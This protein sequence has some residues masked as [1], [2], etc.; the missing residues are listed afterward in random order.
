M[1]RSL[2]SVL[3]HGFSGRM[4]PLVERNWNFLSSLQPRCT[5]FEQ[6]RP[7]E[8]SSARS[9]FWLSPFIG[10]VIPPCI[11]MRC[12]FW[13]RSHLLS[14]NSRTACK[15]GVSLL[16]IE[17]QFSHGCY[18]HCN[19]QHLCQCYIIRLSRADGRSPT[20]GQ[21]F[22]LSGSLAAPFTASFRDTALGL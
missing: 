18:P 17:L 21:V 11:G 8:W 5:S 15:V 10:T 4:Y 6:L 7:R 13:R 12:R 9:L 14:R 16:T 19:N 3:S 20:V 2:Q 22:A 1:I